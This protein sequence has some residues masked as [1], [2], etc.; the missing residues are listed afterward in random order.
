MK[1]SNHHKGQF[2]KLS[3]Y[4]VE[5]LQKVILKIFSIKKIYCISRCSCSISCESFFGETVSL[6]EGKHLNIEHTNYLLSML[7]LVFCR[8]GGKIENM[9]EELSQLLNLVMTFEDKKTQVL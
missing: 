6:S 1:K 5:Q 2:V 7:C 3:K 9:N 4:G 8:S